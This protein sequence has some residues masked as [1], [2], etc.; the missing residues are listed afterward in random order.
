MRAER[1]A[2]ASRKSCPQAERVDEHEQSVPMDATEHAVAPNGEQ[3]LPRDVSRGRHSDTWQIYKTN[4]A[5]DV[6][7]IKHESY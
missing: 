6:G 1:S 3:S 2:V 5:S 4:C 7:D